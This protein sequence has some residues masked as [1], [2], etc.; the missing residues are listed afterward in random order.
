MRKQL[1]RSFSYDFLTPSLFPRPTLTTKFPAASSLVARTQSMHSPRFVLFL[2]LSACSSGSLTR[3][4]VTAPAATD[5]ITWHAAAALPSGRD[6]HGTFIT[7]RNDNAW[8]W[9]VGGNDYRRTFAEVWRARIG[10]DGIPG[11]WSTSKNLPN[12]RAGMGVAQTDQFVMLTGGMDSSQ[13]KTADVLIAHI[14]GDGTLGAWIRGG[15]MP[16]PRFHHSTV[17]D[18][19][20]LYVVGGLEGSVSVPTVLRATLDKDGGI[21]RW[22][23]LPPLPRPRSHNS[24]FVHGRSLYL[25]GGLDGNPA[26]PNTPLAD[27]VRAPILGDGTLGAWEEVGR[28]DHAYGTHATAVHDG[29]VWLF[30][31][32]EDN[33]RFVDVVLRAPIAADGTVGPWVNVKPAL[34]AARSHVH[35][36]PVF[37]GRVYSTAGSNRRVV[38]GDVQVGTFVSRAR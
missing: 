13:R 18:G 4:A 5:S 16:G 27:V 25:V 11:E 23:S 33:A 26:G 15:V 14:V 8:L 35:Q 20:Y 7:S 12:A 32:V 34:P 36:A 28:M 24:I 31:G 10:A 37:R 19:R 3:T 17:M 2:A 6:H 29:A 21:V 1:T 9:V 30:G 38:T 22:D